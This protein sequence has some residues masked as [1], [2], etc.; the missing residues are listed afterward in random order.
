MRVTG[1]RNDVR[2]AHLL[3][4][5]DRKL[6]LTREN[7]VVVVS[8]PPACTDDIDS[9]V[10]LDLPDAPRTDPPLL[11]QGSDSAFNL[12]YLSAVTTGK[13]VKR[14]NRDGRFHISKWTEPGDSAS[15][16]LL[17]SQTET[18]RVRIRFIL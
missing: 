4:S 8:L 2:G 5:P 3:A 1:L 7:D 9:V 15:W 10:V 17:V 18:Y 12:D 14:F 6:A 11:N 13:A 16:N